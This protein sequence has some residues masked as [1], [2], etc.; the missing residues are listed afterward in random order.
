MERG[1]DSRR[2]RDCLRCIRCTTR[3]AAQLVL[4]RV[5][6]VVV[7]AAVVLAVLAAHGKRQTACCSVQLSCQPSARQ[8]P[9]T[10]HD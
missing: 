2:P 10:C 6:V 1:R 8:A 4:G 3:N 7:V 9:K 5:H